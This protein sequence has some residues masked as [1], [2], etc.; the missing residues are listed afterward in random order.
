MEAEDKAVTVEDGFYWAR[1]KDSGKL[2]IFEVS[3]F[4]GTAIWIPGN[5]C[6][7]DPEEIA[8]DWD[9]LDRIEPPKEKPSAP[10]DA[11]G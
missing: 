9:I 2:T 4:G 11:K 6:P 5:D 3:D 1:R 7:H 8:P 10:D